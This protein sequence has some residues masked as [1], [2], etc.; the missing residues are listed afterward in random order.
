MP[1]MP[2]RQMQTTLLLRL[3]GLVPPVGSSGRVLEAD[4]VA[5]AALLRAQLE[6]QLKAPARP[7]LNACLQ[8]PYRGCAVLA[9]IQLVCE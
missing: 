8:P 5:D 9:C 1:D 4:L 2:A 6:G 7:L 3:A